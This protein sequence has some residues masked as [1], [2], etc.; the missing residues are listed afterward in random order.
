MKVVIK[1]AHE[2]YT[3]MRDNLI[4][5]AAKL[6][7]STIAEDIVQNSFE[8][9]VKSKKELHGPLVIATVRNRCLSYL[10]NKKEETLPAEEW[11]ADRLDY[12]FDKKYTDEEWRLVLQKL[13]AAIDR[14]PAQCKIA[15]LLY[16]IE[17]K[18]SNKIAKIMKCD[19]STVTSQLSRGRSILKKIL[20]ADKDMPFKKAR[21]NG[22]A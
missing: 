20:S 2:L 11:L 9:L 14:L 16:Y 18:D 12:S 19:M 1:E 10:H 13:S 7:G 21:G 22:L 17:G 5:F 4:K 8:Q 15:I 3:Q 6:V